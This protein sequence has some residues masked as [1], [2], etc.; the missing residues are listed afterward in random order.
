MPPALFQGGGWSQETITG[1]PA[2][3]KITV[4]VNKPEDPAA[5]T[6]MEEEGAAEEPAAGEPTAEEPAAEE[7]S[8]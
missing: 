3:Q 5:E 8:S 2:P 1:L 4:T 7:A 6:P